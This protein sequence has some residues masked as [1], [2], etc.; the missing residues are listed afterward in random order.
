MLGSF[1]AGYSSSSSDEDQNKNDGNGDKM[2][3]ND[4]IY[5]QQNSMKQII[6]NGN[7]NNSKSKFKQTKKLFSI[8]DTLNMIPDQQDDSDSD[9]YLDEKNVIDGA[10]TGEQIPINRREN[11]ERT[12]HQ[13][14]Q[15]DIQLAMK[16]SGESYHRVAPPSIEVNML[17]TKRKQPEK[18]VDPEFEDNYQI[19]ANHYG[20]NK[21]MRLDDRDIQH[22]QQ[23]TAPKNLATS[24][25]EEE[26]KTDIIGSK[27][28]EM[29]LQDQETSGVSEKSQVQ[30]QP[31]KP[32]V[33]ASMR[34]KQRGIDAKKLITEDQN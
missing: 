9:N 1:L 29:P 16:Y 22:N 8:K 28:M 13:M 26:R 20:N 30:Q 23:T 11:K 15:K 3:D 31:K 25:M 12:K 21:Y 6:N 24:H 32:F 27:K 17:K 19:E 5:Q 33:P 18:T 7:S 34:N 10:N 2:E 4:D 14:M